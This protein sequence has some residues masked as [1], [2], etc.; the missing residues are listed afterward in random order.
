MQNQLENLKS[1][2]SLVPISFTR[3]LDESSKKK[4]WTVGPFV[5]QIH[6]EYLLLTIHD[7]LQADRKTSMLS[8]KQTV[9]VFLSS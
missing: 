1:Q 2:S 7:T 4:L 6:F 5:L 8:I 3:Q 9:T